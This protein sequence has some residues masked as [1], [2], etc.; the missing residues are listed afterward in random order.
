M[1]AMNRQRFFDPC[2]N[3]DRIDGKTPNLFFSSLQQRHTRKRCTVS[4]KKKASTTE[5]TAVQMGKDKY[6]QPS[7]W[8]YTG[9]VSI[10]DGTTWRHFTPNNSPLAHWQVVVVEFDANGNLWASPYS[11]GAVQITL[12]NA[13]TPTPTPTPTTVPPPRRQ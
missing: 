7:T 2:P 8:P 4:G 11:E 5:A 10:F 1:A 12:G 9:G 6:N 3:S 13:P